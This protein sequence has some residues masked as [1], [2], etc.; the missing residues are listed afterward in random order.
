MQILI[1]GSGQRGAAVLGETHELMLSLA[2]LL[3]KSQGV[4]TAEDLSKSHLDR[5]RSR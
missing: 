5:R 3:E 2:D 4:K 1:L